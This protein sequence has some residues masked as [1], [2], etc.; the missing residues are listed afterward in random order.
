[1]KVQKLKLFYTELN[2]NERH[3]HDIG[4]VQEKMSYQKYLLQNNG[5][6]ALFIIYGYKIPKILL[7]KNLLIIQK[8]NFCKGLLHNVLNPKRKM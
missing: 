1:M 4:R 8:K 2:C 6:N 3:Q 7:I 5:N